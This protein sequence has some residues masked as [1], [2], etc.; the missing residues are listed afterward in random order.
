VGIEEV[1]EDL[2]VTDRDPGE[3]YVD[4]EGLHHGS[5]LTEFLA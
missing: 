4:L 2:F 3:V 5:S 1:G